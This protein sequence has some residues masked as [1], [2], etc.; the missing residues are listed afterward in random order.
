M[1][2]RP[3]LAKGVLELLGARTI[4]LVM[5]AY[6]AVGLTTAVHAQS[7]KIT[8][9]VFPLSNEGGLATDA[10]LARLGQELAAICPENDEQRKVVAGLGKSVSK[11]ASRVLTQSRG[12]SAKRSARILKSLLTSLGAPP[13]S[14]EAASAVLLAALQP[15][16]DEA[17]SVAAGIDV[18]SALDD[19]KQAVEG[20]VAESRTKAR[21]KA[22]TDALVASHAIGDLASRNKSLSRLVGKAVT[23]TLKPKT[24]VSGEEA[25]KI[26]SL[27]LNII[28]YFDTTSLVVPFRSALAAADTN[29]ALS[30]IALARRPRFAANLLTRFSAEDRSHINDFFPTEMRRL[31]PIGPV[32][33]YTM[34]TIEGEVPI[35]FA[36]DCD[37]V[38]R[39]YEI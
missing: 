19:L 2:L 30:F 27:A 16:P 35:T 17:P 37:G 25:A 21:L 22:D 38:W 1:P 7:D 24:N 31:G 11:L 14:I 18:A 28:Y 34:S 3:L 6:V 36:A 39:I 9:E 15:D 4:A 23:A 8:V 26:V 5:G 13:R 29:R 32:V 10:A 12:K 20:L 33:T